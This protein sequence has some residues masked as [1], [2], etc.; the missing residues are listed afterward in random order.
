MVFVLKQK[1]A[2]L[3]LNKEYIMNC[4]ACNKELFEV[5]AGEIKVDVCKQGCGGIWFDNF[6][7]EKV[8]EKHE[9]AGEE[10]LETSGR[11]KGPVV[12]E[13]KRNCPRCENITMIEHFSGAKQK[14][15]IDECPQCGGVWLDCGELGE[16]RETYPT[17]AE[18]K[19]AAVEFFENNFAGHLAARQ[20][21]EEDKLNKARRFASIFRFV[22]P[23]YYLPGKQKWGA[24]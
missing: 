24:F 4:P 21:Q 10:L 6:E 17:E 2:I 8:D 20:S 13:N 14:V 15:L 18:R 7:L 19:R 16:I 11:A 3:G 12:N 23:S 5:E 1:W 9:A 22:C